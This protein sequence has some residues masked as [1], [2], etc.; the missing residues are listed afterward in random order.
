MW[1]RRGEAPEPNKTLGT[2]WDSEGCVN[3]LYSLDTPGDKAKERQDLI[4]RNELRK[5]STCRVNLA[6]WNYLIQ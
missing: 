4:R 6:R 5:R 2:Y 3:G 1:T